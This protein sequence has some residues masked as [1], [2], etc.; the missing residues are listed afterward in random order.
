MLNALC[1]MRRAMFLLALI[2]CQPAPGPAE[3]AVHPELSFAR[4]TGPHAGIAC[5][6]CHD[7]SAG[8]ADKGGKNVTCTGC[9]TGEHQQAQVDAHHAGVDGYAY[10]GANPRFCLSCHPAGLA[11]AAHPEDRFPIAGGA[12][13]GV[14]CGECHDRALGPSRN[15]ANSNCVRCHASVSPRHERVAGFATEGT[16]PSFCLACHPSGRAPAPHPE[17]SFAIDTGAHAAARCAECHDDARGSPVG[18]ANTTCTSCHAQPAADA[19]HA[20]DPSYRFNAT[21][22]AFCLSCHPT[23]RAA[24]A[25]HPE[26]K[27]AIAAGP[28]A[29]IACAACHDA[30]RGT[31]L[32]GHNTICTSCHTQPAVDPLHAGDPTYAF[33][34]TNPAFCLSCHPDGRAAGHPELGFPLATGA[35]QG[36]ACAACHDAT[37]G[38]SAG[39][40]NA[41]CVGCHSGTHARAV[42]DQQHLGDPSYAFD[43]TSPA[44]CLRCHPRGIADGVHPETRFRIRSGAHAPFACNDCH[45]PARGSPVGGFNTSCV[46]CHTGEHSRTRVDAEHR[47]VGGYTFDTANPHFCLRCHPSGR[48]D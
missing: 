23:G 19:T 12:H 46:G 37:R 14:G 33:S 27:F 42:V 24:T 3:V 2:G 13:Q 30:A 32:G 29:A 41:N 5:A 38:T 21:N 26:A 8:V 15:G 35:H 9:H 6:D 1:V 4:R 40:A 48:G 43:V 44:F 31:P 34:T 45:V 39:G 10:D 11:S 22:P 25:T 18:G 47:E 16:A 7:R 28:H 20:G 36:I 17:A